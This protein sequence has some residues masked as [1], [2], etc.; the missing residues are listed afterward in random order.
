FSGRLTAPLV[1]AGAIASQLL[2]ARGV[3]AATHVRRIADVMDA[4]FDKT[5]IPKE[6][7]ERLAGVSG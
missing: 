7:A 3:Y 5:D 4:P 6:L 2:K 1:F